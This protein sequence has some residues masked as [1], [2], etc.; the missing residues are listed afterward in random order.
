MVHSI[1]RQEVE[2]VKGDPSKEVTSAQRLEE[3]SEIVLWREKKGEGVG[4]PF[5]CCFLVET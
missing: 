3:M 5:W 4:G 2:L 1:G